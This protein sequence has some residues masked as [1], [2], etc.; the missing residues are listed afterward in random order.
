MPKNERAIN[1]ISRKV[2]QQKTTPQVMADGVEADVVFTDADTIDVGD[3]HNPGVNPQNFVV[4][5]GHQGAY[6]IRFGAQF[7]AGAGLCT[8]YVRV[9][10][11][12]IFTPV[13]C[14]GA[15]AIGAN[16]TFNGLVNLQAGDIITCR[17]T[18]TGVVAGLNLTG[19]LAIIKIAN[20]IT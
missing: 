20:V 4:P 9:N 12:G 18:Q 11:N 13:S 17:A 7:A 19:V 14:L 1:I 8:V 5:A 2:I 6:E 15:A 16:A 3:W 10:G